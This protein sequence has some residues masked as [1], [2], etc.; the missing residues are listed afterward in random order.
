MWTE[1][2][3]YGMSVGRENRLKDVLGLI[4]QRGS[5]TRVRLDSQVISFAGSSKQGK[6][7]SAGHSIL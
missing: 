2:V 1:N 3:E 5:G 6:G 4:Q 7:L